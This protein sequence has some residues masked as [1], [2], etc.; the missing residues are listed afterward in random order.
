MQL[1]PLANIC[2]SPKRSTQLVTNYLILGMTRLM[3]PENNPNHA[4][5]SPIDSPELLALP[6]RQKVVLVM[7]LVESVRLMATN[8]LAVVDHWRGFVRHATKKVL[9][10]HQ[11]RMV[12]SLGDGI[13]AEFEC[14]R[15]AT[16]AALQLHRYFYAANATLPAEQQLF[17]RAGLNTAQVYI[18]DIDIYGSGVNLAARVASLAGPGE[19]IVTTEVRDGLTD[20]LDAKLEDM[21]ECYL[22]HV[23]QPVRAFRVGKAGPAPILMP[24]AGASLSPQPSIAVLPFENANLQSEYAAVGE[25]IADCVAE[26]LCMA[27]E[28]CVVSQHSIRTLRGRSMTVSSVGATLNVDYVLS[29]SCYQI[30]H[31]LDAEMIVSAEL[32]DCRSGHVVWNARFKTSVGSWLQTDSESSYQIAMPVFE[33]ILRSELQQI[34]AKPF[35]NLASYSLLLAAT[36]LMR[37]TSAGDFHQAKTLLG[38]LIERTAR[39]PIGSVWLAKWHV[40]SVEQGWS[41]DRNSSWQQAKNA[42]QNALAIDPNSS[43]ALT[44]DGFAQCNLAKDFD[45][46]LL[47][48]TK[49]LEINPNNS[50]AWL[51]LGML[52]AF[53]GQGEQAVQAVMRAR[54]LSPLDPWRFFYDSLT[55][56]AY[57]SAGQYAQAQKY[58]R[59]SLRLNSSHVS[60]HRV[61]TIALAM[62]GDMQAAK[63]AGALL[64]AIDPALTV[65]G[66][67]ANS[68]GVQFG[69][70]R[71]FADA[72]KAAGI[73]V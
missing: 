20:G 16:N 26:Q 11:G 70:G 1:W 43:L 52:H 13:M 2:T 54:R 63:E 48:Y 66:Y 32:A 49:A 30:G 25:L 6:Q 22:K 10:L 39:N 73:P 64:R 28:I 29:G 57:L 60:T 71:T 41:S 40:L 59:Q 55:A 37:R 35:H 4:A 51:L 50:L 23:A 36:D 7:D 38:A 56:S 44:V 62:G 31:S 27:A 67:L 42:A 5:P 12:K 15:N 46:A 18:D 45:M 19:T 9:P 14:P 21:G 33:A 47:R 3:N 58:A 69:I 68:P 24:S 61:L 8:E 34:A 65:S 72:L 17:L 53:K